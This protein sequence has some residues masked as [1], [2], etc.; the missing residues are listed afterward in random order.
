M[1]WEWPEKPKFDNTCFLSVLPQFIDNLTGCTC[2]SSHSDQSDIGIIHPISINKT[3]IVPPEFF[4]KFPVYFLDYFLSGFNCPCS[5]SSQFHNIFC[6]HESPDHR[7]P[8]RVKYDIRI[9]RRQERINFHLLRDINRFNSMRK[10][11]TI[12]TG[13]YWQK[14]PFIFSDPERLYYH[15]HCFLV[16]FHVKLQPS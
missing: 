2:D 3:S 4:W 13:H 5:L 10:Y 6:R 12:K 16:I 15:I 8:C 14:N 1:S 11:K 9:I 7:R